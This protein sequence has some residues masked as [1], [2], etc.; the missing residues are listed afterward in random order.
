M[1]HIQFTPREQEIIAL[2]TKA[3]LRKNIADRLKISIKTV[4]VHLQNIHKKTGST[5]MSELLLFVSTSSFI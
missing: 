5:T 3:T 1:I 2:I 4:D